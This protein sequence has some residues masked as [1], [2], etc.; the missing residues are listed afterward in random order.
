MNLFHYFDQAFVINLLLML[1]Q[2][3]FSKL[4]PSFLALGLCLGFSEISCVGLRQAQQDNEL[5]HLACFCCVF[6]AI[7]SSLRQIPLYV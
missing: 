4:K 7:C 5:S 2:Q 3:D 1:H 6:V